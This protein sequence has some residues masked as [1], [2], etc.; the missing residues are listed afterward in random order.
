MKKKRERK[1]CI[2]N[3]SLRYPSARPSPLEERRPISSRLV[4][5]LYPHCRVYPSMVPPPPKI[6]RM[7]PSQKEKKK[8]SLGRGCLLDEFDPPRSAFALAGLCSR[9]A[10]SGS[11]TACL[12]VTGCL[13]GRSLLM[14]SRNPV[15][16][17]TRRI[18]P[19]PLITKR[20]RPSRRP[21]SRRR[22]AGRRRGRSARRQGGQRGTRRRCGARGGRRGWARRGAGGRPRGR[23]GCG[24]AASRRR[25]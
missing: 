10:S 8:K 18:S 14:E 1:L 13:W 2:A 23:R 11:R 16:S 12:L 6:L 3:A 21:T 20:R 4:S 7:K 22:G 19:P 5:S 24:R 9:K 25:A 15:N 17:C